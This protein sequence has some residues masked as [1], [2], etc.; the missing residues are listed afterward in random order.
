MTLVACGAPS[1]DTVASSPPVDPPALAIAEAPAPGPHLPPAPTL[2]ASAT[3][4]ELPPVLE[5]PGYGTV[6]LLDPSTPPASAPITRIQNERTIVGSEAPSFTPARD[7]E[8]VEG[9]TSPP[10][11]AMLLSC[12][13]AHVEAVRALWIRDHLGEDVWRAAVAVR[14]DARVYTASPCEGGLQFGAASPAAVVLGAH[15]ATVIELAV[16]RDASDGGYASPRF[17]GQLVSSFANERRRLDLRAPD[18]S[19]APVTDDFASLTDVANTSHQIVPFALCMDGR[20]MLL[21]AHCA[22]GVLLCTY[23]M[24]DFAPCD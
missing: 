4:R 20:A 23:R 22:P 11:E 13:T 7:L 19:I 5:L 21:G 14:S 6:V 8:I 9:A 16:V 2:A 3:V 12:P 10:F 18:G 17:A 15:T 1:V 24:F